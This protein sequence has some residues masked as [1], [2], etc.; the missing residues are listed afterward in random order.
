MNSGSSLRVLISCFALNK[1]QNSLFE[2][3]LPTSL[4]DM[5][6][7]LLLGNVSS[8]HHQLDPVGRQKSLTFY[9]K[10]PG[11]ET[12]V[13]AAA[14]PLTAAHEYP[15]F[16]KLCLFSVLPSLPIIIWYLR[17]VTLSQWEPLKMCLSSILFG[18]VLAFWH[19]MNQNTLVVP[20]SQTWKWTLFWIWLYGQFLLFWLAEFYKFML[21][22]LIYI[23]Q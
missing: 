6:Q 12:W 8:W 1:F 16:T 18:H 2:N 11:I 3:S 14:S 15:P 5:L 17:P 9:R 13:L 23:Y 4:S 19:T 21:K 20:L 10:S 7:G 22:I